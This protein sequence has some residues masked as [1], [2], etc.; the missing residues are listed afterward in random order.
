M[1]QFSLFL[2]VFG[3]LS[4]LLSGPGMAADDGW[5]FVDEEDE[6]RLYKKSVA[7]S[8]YDAF[9]ATTVVNATMAAV[10]AVLRDVPV[11]P[12]WMARISEARILKQYDANNMDVY[13]VM[14]FPWPTSDREAVIR[15]KTAVDPATGNV[16]VTTQVIQE[17]P[18]PPNKDLVRVPRL[19]QQFCLTYKDFDTTAVSFSLHMEAGGNL[20]AFTVNPATQDVPCQSLK[21]LQDIVDDAPYRTADP[22]DAVNLPITRTIITAILK[23]YIQDPAIIEMV[24]SDKK[25]MDIA[26][27]GG[28]S[29]E[30]LRETTTAII[31][32]YVHTPMY[33]RTIQSCKDRVLLEN[34]TRNADLLNRLAAEDAIVELV[35]ESGGM[36]D[37][38][39]AAVAAYVKDEQE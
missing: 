33:A 8:A 6:V 10:G 1:K 5:T 31:K 2:I 30:G 29:R 22:L 13:L 15:G 9:K 4:L 36:T 14:D 34:L 32:K 37:R 21:N 20:P 19:A 23:D 3:V 7:G 11:Y 17:T 25:T 16:T 26:I 24:I 27:R 12:Q 38:V 35:L 39:I 18:V 28:Y